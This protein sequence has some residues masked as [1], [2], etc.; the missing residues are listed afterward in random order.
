MIS[1][2]PL[3]VTELKYRGDPKKE[4]VVLKART[5]IKKGTKF[6]IFDETFDAE[7]NPSNLDRH[8]YTLTIEEDVQRDE[9]ILI[10]TRPGDFYATKP[11]GK[12]KQHQYY[13]GLKES[14]WNKDQTEIVH[15]VPVTSTATKKSFPPEEEQ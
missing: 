1:L 3:R 7:G 9:M 5:N 4:F 11:D 6:L 10:I 14:V 15:V 12:V 2:R 13:W 8:L